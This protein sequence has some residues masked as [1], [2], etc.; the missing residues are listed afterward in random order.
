MDGQTDRHVVKLT[1]T[2]FAE[3]LQCVLSNVQFVYENTNCNRF[4]CFCR[5]KWEMVGV[6]VLT[7]R[8]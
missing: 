7:G 3:V 8:R 1:V 4:D 6:S 5:Y 2:F